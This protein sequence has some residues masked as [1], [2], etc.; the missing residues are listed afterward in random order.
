MSSLYTAFSSENNYFSRQCTK[1][2][3]TNDIFMCSDNIKAV[4]LIKPKFYFY[5]GNLVLNDN[6]YFIKHLM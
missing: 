4:N 3:K 5:K 6:L 2:S 1:A